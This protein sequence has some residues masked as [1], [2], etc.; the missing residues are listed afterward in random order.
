MNLDCLKLFYCEF[1]KDQGMSMSVVGDQP[2]TMEIPVL[3]QQNTLNTL[4]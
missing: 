1:Q 2:K 4:F 3:K